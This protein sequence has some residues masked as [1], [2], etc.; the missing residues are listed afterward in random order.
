VSLRIVQNPPDKYHP[1]QDSE[2]LTEMYGAQVQ[3]LNFDKLMN[4]GVLHTKLWVIDEQHFYLG[5]ANMDWR[6]L[7]QVVG[8]L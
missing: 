8:K 3:N 4:G 1:Q 2:L 6:S 5:S 7:T